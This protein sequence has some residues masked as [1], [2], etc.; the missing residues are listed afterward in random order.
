MSFVA[1]GRLVEAIKIWNSNPTGRTN[2]SACPS[3]AAQAAPQKDRCISLCFFLESNV[4]ELI[5]QHELVVC[6]KYT[7]LSLYL[8][9]SITNARHVPFSVSAIYCIPH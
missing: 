8:L 1:G 6:Y 3:D 7:F 5:E 4:L 9:V 2:I